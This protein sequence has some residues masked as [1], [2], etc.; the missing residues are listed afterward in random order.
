[1]TAPGVLTR[2]KPTTSKPS[3]RAHPLQ[4]GDVA[5]A[6]VAEVEVGPDHDQ[7]G[8]EAAVEHL[9]HEV[10]GRFPPAGLVEGEDDGVVDEAGGLEELQLL[11]EAGE[12]LGGG[13]R[14]GPPGPG[15][16]RR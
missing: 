11:V 1:M 12:Q 3:S 9:A 13:L 4:Q 2:S 16:G 7:P 5:P 14:A 10:L 15:G 6:G 8:L